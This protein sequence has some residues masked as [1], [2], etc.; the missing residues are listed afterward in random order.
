MDRRI[1]ETY[2]E[3]QLAPTL[4]PGDVV[5]LDNLPAHKSAAAEQADP[6]PAAA[7]RDALRSRRLHAQFNVV[8]SGALEGAFV[9]PIPV[10]RTSACRALIGAGAGNDLD[11]ADN[12]AACLGC[13]VHARIARHDGAVGEIVRAVSGALR[14]IGGLLSLNTQTGTGPAPLDIPTGSLVDSSPIIKLKGKD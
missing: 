9:S 6:R 11:F 4:K 7:R 2:V 5:V 1:F 10:K 13:G 3:T 8:K 12:M 14:V